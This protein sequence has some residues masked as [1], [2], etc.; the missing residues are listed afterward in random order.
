[1]YVCILYIYIYVHIPMYICILYIYTHMY[2]HMFMYICLYMDIARLLALL[3]QKF[4][5]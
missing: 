3:V 1:M 4:E 2:I 5:Y